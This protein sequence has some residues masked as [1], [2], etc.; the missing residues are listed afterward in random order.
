LRI[1][2]GDLNCNKYLSEVDKK[3]VQ[4]QGYVLPD[5]TRLTSRR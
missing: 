3:V 4:N 5:T 2:D 1:D